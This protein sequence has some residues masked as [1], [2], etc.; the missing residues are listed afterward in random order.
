MKKRIL[1]LYATY[2]SGHK[3]IANYIKKYFEENGEYECL[4]LD[5]NNYV[6]RISS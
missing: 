5:L 3:A 4:S 6:C 1:I 2:G